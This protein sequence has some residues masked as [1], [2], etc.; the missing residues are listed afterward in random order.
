MAF[1][2][3]ADDETGHISAEGTY[4]GETPFLDGYLRLTS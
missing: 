1:S 4:T 3:D 2:L